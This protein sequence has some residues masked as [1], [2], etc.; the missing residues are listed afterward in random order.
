MDQPEIT[1]EVNNENTS[2]ISEADTGFRYFPFFNKKQPVF[3]LVLIGLIFYC[4][5]LDNEYALDDG[6]V[7]HQ[8][9]YVLEGVSGIDDI[10][11]KDLYYSFYERMNA[12]DQLQGGRYHPLTVMTYALEQEAIGPY[13]SGFYMQLEDL[14][15]N[16][17]LDKEKV[18]YSGTKENYEYNAYVDLNHDGE[19]QNNECYTCW[20]LNKNFKNDPSEDLNSDGV[21]NEVDCQVNGAGMRHFTNVW[22]YILASVLIYLV[23][24]RCFFK[25]NQDIA[26]LAALIFLIHPIH[27]EI[28]AN[29]KGRADIMGLIFMALCFLYSFKFF[30]NKKISSLLAASVMLWLALL[31]REFSVTLLVLVPLGIHVFTNGKMNWRVIGATTV[32]FLIFFTAILLLKMSLFPDI[33]G[34]LLIFPGA[35]IFLA[36]CAALFRQTIAERDFSALMIGFFTFA[37]LYSGMRINAV[38]VAPGIPDTEILN[39]P[40][41]LANGAEKFATKIVVLMKYL[42]L[43]VFPQNLNSDYSFN[44]IPYYQLTDFSFLASLLINIGLVLTGIVLS[45]RHH[46]LGFAI[47]SYYIVLMMVANLFFPIGLMMREGYLF[48]ASIGIAIA[49][50]WLIIKGMDRLQKVSFANRRTVLLLS[51]LVVMVLCGA[52][53]WERNYDWKNDVTLFLKEVKTNPNSVLVLG[54]AGARWIDL[55]DTKEITGI[56][57]PGQDSTRFNDYNGTLKITDEEMRAGGYKNKQETALHK[58]ITYLTHAVDLHPRYVNGYLNLGLAWYK[59][60][61][62]LKAIYYWKCAEHLYPNNPYLRN[63]YDVFTNVLKNRGSDAFGKEQWNDA[64]KNYTMWKI[65]APKDP[66]PLFHSAGVW[67]NRGD[68]EK[69]KT[70]LEKALKLNPNHSDSRKLFD[71][72][73]Q[74]NR[75]APS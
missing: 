52:K 34:S 48:N 72:L 22:M 61:D 32:L 1:P 11:T 40:Y 62:Y 37:L 66:D 69:S 43:S 71:L 28:V 54:N 36:I 26:F 44:T 16:G 41:L 49:F 13:R 18:F 55:A 75:L 50:G 63:Y 65:T 2:V 8:N 5:S 7:I 51:S 12:T 19:A 53:T 56:N 59:L 45:I 14:N 15:G 6:I 24:S 67:F 73:Q 17:K 42:I 47:I 30:E 23:F 46:V 33:H 68:Y 3:A 25:G 29:V 35:L 4:T 60:G 64:L 74:V 27:S 9:S 10:F 20:D 58:G 70:E 39:N 38:N 21:F 57:V 31:S